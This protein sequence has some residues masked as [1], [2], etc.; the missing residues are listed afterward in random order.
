MGEVVPLEEVQGHRVV[1]EDQAEVAVQV[2]TTGQ[3]VMMADLEVTRD[4]AVGQVAATGQGVM[5]ADLEVTR[6]MAVGQAVDGVKDPL[7]EAGMTPH[8]TTPQCTMTR[9]G[10]SR[11]GYSRRFKQSTT[12]L[13]QSLPLTSSI[14]QCRSLR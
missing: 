13:T 5:M 8:P 11:P 12:L 9:R 1:V 4:M 3:G 6:D 14:T 7:L 10:T 2:A